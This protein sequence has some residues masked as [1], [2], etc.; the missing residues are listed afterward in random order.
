M[1]AEDHSELED[2]LRDYGA[3]GAAAA[4][5]RSLEVIRAA[6]AAEHRSSRPVRRPLPIRS[7]LAAALTAVLVTIGL[8]PA[9]AD[10]RQLVEDTFTVEKVAEPPLRLPSDGAILTTNRDGAWLASSGGSRRFLGPYEAAA[11]SPRGLNVAVASGRELAAVDRL[12]ELQWELTA[13]GPVADPVWAPSAL[14]IAYRAGPQLRIVEGD[15][16]PDR[17][18]DRRVGDAAPAWRPPQ[19]GEPPRDLVAYVGAGGSIR[20]VDAAE[21]GAG[22][23]VATAGRPELLEWLDDG[24]LVVAGDEAVELFSPAGERLASLPR[25]ARAT[26]TALVAEPGAARV[27]IASLRIGPEGARSEISLLRLEPGRTRASAIYSSSGELAG[28]AFS[29]D[30][31]WLAAGLPATDSWLFLRPLEQAKL[32]R[33]TETL[34]GVSARFDGQSA[35]PPG[36]PAIAEWGLLG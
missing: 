2:R 25:P 11:L 36:F 31:R 29:P 21:Q 7:L 10:V 19:D 3:A 33:R 4:E 34:A 20:I 22:L 28:I 23:E 13:R 5:E 9:G 30:G 12:G 17:L 32:L 6:F 8:T 35:V 18:L 15:G 26:P 16:E 27:A 1:S 24:R 14:R